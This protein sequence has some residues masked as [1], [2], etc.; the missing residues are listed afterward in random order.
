[1]NAGHRSPLLVVRA[2][3]GGKGRNKAQAASASVERE[4]NMGS[5]GA[6]WGG[7]GWP[8]A[9]P[10][11]LIE[12]T[13]NRRRMR[14]GKRRRRRRERERDACEKASSVQYA[15]AAHRP[16]GTRGSAKRACV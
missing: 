6:A 5:A 13:K 14:M 2:C 15:A 9:A 7:V 16:V 10:R 4:I 12:K 3:E 11:I 8:R 1:M